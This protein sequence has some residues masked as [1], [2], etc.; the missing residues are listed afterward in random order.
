VERV[1]DGSSVEGDQPKDQVRGMQRWEFSR[2][3]DFGV[4]MA[5]KVVSR[6]PPISLYMIVART[7]GYTYA[8]IF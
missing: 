5:H 6:R 7:E 1:R 2:I 8:P 4:E 3:S